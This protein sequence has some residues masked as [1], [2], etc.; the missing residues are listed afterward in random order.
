MENP[1]INFIIQ[2]PLDTSDPEAMTYAFFGK[3][4][5]ELVQDIVDNRNGKYAYLF[6]GQDSPAS[7]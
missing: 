5:A 3:S 4:V 1:K 7:C 2:Q 6:N